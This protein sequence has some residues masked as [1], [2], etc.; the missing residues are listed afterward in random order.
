M[1]TSLTDPRQEAS[2]TVTDAPREDPGTHL[3]APSGGTTSGRL[4]RMQASV[5]DL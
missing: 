4:G 3:R 1:S 5:R 2:L